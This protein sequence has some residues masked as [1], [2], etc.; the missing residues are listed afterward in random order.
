MIC[1]Y[2]IQ[3]SSNTIVVSALFS[4]ATR[5]DFWLY[6]FGYPTV[7]K[8]STWT[9]TLVVLGYSAKKLQICYAS[10][11]WSN[12]VYQ[13]IRRCFADGSQVFNCKENEPLLSSE[14]V[15]KGKWFKQKIKTPSGLVSEESSSALSLGQE[16]TKRNEATCMVKVYLT[17]HTSTPGDYAGCYLPFNQISADAEN[18]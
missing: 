15:D 17:R 12:G 1:Y 11:Q 14:V 10:K 4:L 18:C 13:T 5:N 3:N 6:I 8:R 16:S 2:L 7:T 9:M